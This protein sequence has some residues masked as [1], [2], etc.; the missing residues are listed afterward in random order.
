VL[1]PF[2]RVLCQGM[3]TLSVGENHPDIITVQLAA[4]VGDAAAVRVA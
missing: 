1:F 4:D 2:P 3:G